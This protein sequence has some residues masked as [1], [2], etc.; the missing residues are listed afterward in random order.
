M[1]ILNAIE[2]GETMQVSTACPE[3]GDIGLTEV[4]R[5]GYLDW[6]NGELIQRAM[7][8]LSAERRERLVTGICGACW[9]AMFAE[10]G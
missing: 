8:E 5:Q 6:R 2:T 9:G 7:P 4:P 3:C 10:E 1:A